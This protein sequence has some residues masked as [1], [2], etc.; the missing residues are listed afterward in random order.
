[1]AL[2]NNFTRRVAMGTPRGL[3]C[4]VIRAYSIMRSDPSL[5]AYLRNL[6]PPP[7]PPS[8]LVSREI[9]DSTAVLTE[10]FVDAIKVC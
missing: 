1:M 2:Y 5:E 8:V 4:D 6:V 10:A 3:V 7:F 9:K